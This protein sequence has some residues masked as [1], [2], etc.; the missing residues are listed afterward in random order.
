M[1]GGFMFAAFIGVAG[2]NGIM[3]G[4]SVKSAVDKPFLNKLSKLG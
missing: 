3:A 2:I 4:G 1:N